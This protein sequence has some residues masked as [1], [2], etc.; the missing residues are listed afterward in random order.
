MINR[1]MKR[2]IVYMVRWF[3]VP[4]LALALAACAAPE[5]GPLAVG[6]P[7]PDFRLRS[8]DGAT[9]SLADFRD[10][11]PVLLFFHMAVG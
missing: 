10:Q 7:A 8:V 9:F 11:R 4:G 5:A 6:D 1:L 3:V 2:V